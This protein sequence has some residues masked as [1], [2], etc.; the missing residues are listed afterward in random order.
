MSDPSESFL[1]R[2]RRT[3]WHPYTQHAVDRE[4]LA[5]VGARG[6]LLDLAD[7][8]QLIDAISSWWVC[9]HGHGE[10]Q[11]IEA[12]RAQALRLDHV[13]FAGTTHAP[14]LDLADALLPLAPRGLTRLFFSDNG[15]SAVEVALKMAYQRHALGGEPQRSVFVA[16]EGSYHGDTFGAMSVGD[17]D[18]FFH[19]FASMLFEVRRVRPELGAFAAALDE[20]GERAAGVIVEPLVQGAGGMRM[21]GHDVLRDARAATAARGLPLIADEVMTGFGRTGSLFACGQAGVEPDLMCLAKGLTGG[22][23]PMAA[24][25]AREEYF[26]AFL[27]E[28]RTRTF[29][30]GHSFTAHPIGCAVALASL[31]LVQERDTPGLLD[32]AGARIEARLRE[33][34]GDDPRARDLRRTGGIVAVDVV[35]ADGAPEGYLA[36]L[37]PRLRAA[38]IERGVL[39]RPLGDV[40][41]A[42]PPACIDAAQAD[43]IAETMA[44]LVELA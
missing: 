16:L 4:R 7:G 41:Y 20:L 33:R 14:A 12:M 8:R 43:Q 10:P 28:D 44:Q 32:A 29:F 2:D 30:H 25:L 37:G 5:V 3:Q 31:A 11:L 17:P 9:L 34:L 42:M 1:A 24:T 36:S 35:P 27:S 38:A 15:S 26:E 19:T 6:A 40:L 22:F 23:M 21:H 13:L 39:L 18:P